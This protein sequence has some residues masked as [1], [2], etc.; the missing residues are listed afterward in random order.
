MTV[1]SCGEQSPAC[2]PTDS[3][4]IMVYRPP[5]LPWQPHSDSLVLGSCGEVQQWAEAQAAAGKRT[6]G[7]TCAKGSLVWTLRVL[8]RGFP[9]DSPGYYLSLTSF[10]SSDVIPSLSSLWREPLVFHMRDLPPYEAVMD[11]ADS[12]WRSGAKS[13]HYPGKMSK[14][15]L[16]GKFL[17]FCSIITVGRSNEPINNLFKGRQKQPESF[18]P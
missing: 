16:K 10:V 5:R 12:V 11:P 3:C 2:Y 15:C 8:Q 4:I 9:P 18:Y 1:D 6:C 13:H 17:Y 7:T 14:C